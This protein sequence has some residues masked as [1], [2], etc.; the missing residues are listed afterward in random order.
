MA[1]GYRKQH[2]PLIRP[3]IEVD[4]ASHVTDEETNHRAH[5]KGAE[6][7]HEGYGKRQPGSCHDAAENVPPEFMG[8]GEVAPG[9]MQANSEFVYGHQPD[10][11]AAKDTGVR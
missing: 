3:R 4:S 1:G 11:G 2:L 6:Y 8:A 9:G 5:G 10:T 7:C